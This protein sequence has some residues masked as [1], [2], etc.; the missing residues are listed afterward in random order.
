MSRICPGSANAN[1]PLGPRVGYDRRHRERGGH[2][3]DRELPFERRG[4][5]VFHRWPPQGFV[6]ERHPTRIVGHDQVVLEKLTERRGDRVRVSVAPELP[7]IGPS[8]ASVAFG[9]AGQQDHGVFAQ[10]GEPML[11]V[12][13]DRVRQ[14]A[15]RAL[16]VVSSQRAERK[17]VLHQQLE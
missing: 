17:E 12:L 1:G 15:P 4:G 14:I 2:R 16:V 9:D 11:P 5:T 3:G 8:Y 13:P 6:R 7:E 10:A